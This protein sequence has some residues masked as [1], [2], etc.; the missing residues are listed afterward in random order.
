MSI[1]YVE[2]TITDA[3]PNEVTISAV[4]EQGPPGTNG[5]NGTPGPNLIDSN[6]DVSFPGTGLIGHAGGKATSV[7]PGQFATDAELA[8]AVAPYAPLSLSPSNDVYLYSSRIFVDPSI[9]GAFGLGGTFGQ[10]HRIGSATATCVTG[11]G[12]TT[13]FAADSAYPGGIVIASVIGGYDTI[14][15]QTGGGTILANHCMVKHNVDGHSVIVGGST[16]VIAGRRSGMFTSRS[17]EIGPTAGWSTILSSDNCEIQGSFHCLIAGLDCNISP[18]SWY[19]FIVGRDILVPSNQYGVWAQGERYDTPAPYSHTI[20]VRLIERNDCRSWRTIDVRDTNNQTSLSNMT[21][22]VNAA[23]LPVGKVTAGL[24]RVRVLALRDG[25]ADGNNDDNFACGSWEGT[26]GFRWNGTSYTL[27]NST[28]S[29]TDTTLAIP[30]V[31]DDIGVAATPM[32]SCS[33]GRPRVQISG[34][35]STHIKWV[36]DLEI[37]STLES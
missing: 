30:L 21:Y 12:S 2:L 8:A 10:P 26:I 6:T 27:W 18:D 5:T 7:D 32:F 15:N 14:V 34:R 33:T 9:V 31:R 29:V 37:L 36:V 1:E 3:E 4:G 22:L 35:A 28:T 20:G 17:S 16:C 24:C 11:N 23:P 19:G 25:S 13:N